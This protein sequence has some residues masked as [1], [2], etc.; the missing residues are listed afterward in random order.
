M[1]FLARPEYVDAVIVKPD[2]ESIVAAMHAAFGNDWDGSTP[3]LLVQHV[4]E[5]GGIYIPTDD[6]VELVPFGHWLVVRSNGDCLSVSAKA[7]AQKYI[8]SVG[9]ARADVTQH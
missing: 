1:K 2:R 9:P 8:P 4:I 6:G 3:E 5:H 7:F